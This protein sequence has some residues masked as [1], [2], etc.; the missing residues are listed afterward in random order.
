MFSFGDDG[1]NQIAPESDSLAGFGPGNYQDGYVGEGDRIYW[2]DLG[3]MDPADFGQQQFNQNNA[4]NL[5]LYYI[6]QQAHEFYDLGKATAATV[7][8]LIALLTLSFLSLRTVER[9]VHYET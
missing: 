3:G 6:Y 9:K 7:V 1:L 8:T 5:L 2:G 4:T